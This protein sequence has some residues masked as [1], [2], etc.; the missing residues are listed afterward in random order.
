MDGNNTLMTGFSLAAFTFP[1]YRKYLRCV[2]FL[3]AAFTVPSGLCVDAKYINTLPSSKNRGTG[4]KTR[5]PRV[6]IALHC[7]SILMLF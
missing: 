2:G 5:I 1:S 6:I 3:W 7:I 4:A